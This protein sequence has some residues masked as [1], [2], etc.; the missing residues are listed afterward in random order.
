MPKNR[1]I[2]WLFL[3]GCPL[4]NSIILRFSWKRYSHDSFLSPKIEYDA[5]FLFVW[6]KCL[7]II[8]HSNCSFQRF[9]PQ[10]LKICALKASDRKLRR[11]SPAWQEHKNAALLTN[12]WDWCRSWM[13]YIR[14]MFYSITW[15]FISMTFI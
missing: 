8:I 10:S 12:R 11:F 9:V 4:I 6:R 15:I 7:K 2:F 3:I 5:V 13:N 14:P 1:Y